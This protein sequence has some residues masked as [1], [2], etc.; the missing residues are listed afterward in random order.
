MRMILF[1]L[2]AT[3]RDT[4]RRRVAL[5]LE[6]LAQRQQLAVLTRKTARPC[7]RSADR[8]FWVLLLSWE[9]E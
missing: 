9:S 1:L 7:L 8:L 6:L 2:F 4:F 5:Q 3:L